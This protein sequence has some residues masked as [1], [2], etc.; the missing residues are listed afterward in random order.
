MQLISEFNKGIRFLLCVIHI[1]SK[2]P[3]VVPL[4]DKKCVTIVNAFQIILDD[5]KRKPNKIWVDKGSEF[6]NRS[7]ESCLQYNN[8]EMYS[9]HNKGK[10]VVG[11]RFIRTLKIS[12]YKYMTLIPKNVYI[13]KLIDIVN[14]YKNTYHRTTMKPVDVKDNTYI[15]TGKEVNDNDPKFQVGDHVRISKYKNIFAKGYPPNWS[16][17]VFVIKKIKNT[18]PRKYVINDLTGEEIVELF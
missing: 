2:Y 15:R 14:E 3:R 17:E 5:S 8:I 10:S 13:D 9:T 18:V 16:D 6:Y 11:E 12:V 4:K 1:F 7:M